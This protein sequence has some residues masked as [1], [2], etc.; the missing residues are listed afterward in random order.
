[1]RAVL[2]GL[3]FAS[4]APAA[5]AQETGDPFRGRVFA[6]QLCSDCH[7]VLREDRASP[8]PAAVRFERIANARGMTGMAL[9]VWLQTSHPTMPNIRLSE[10]KRQDIIAYILSLRTED[11]S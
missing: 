9:D 11:G 7:G 1:M 4:L 5:L 6:A 3:F 8:E 2:P 10:D